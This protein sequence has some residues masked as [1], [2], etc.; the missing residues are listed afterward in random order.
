M[1]PPLASF[2]YKLSALRFG[3]M[4]TNLK[5]DMFTLV[6]LLGYCEYA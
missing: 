4:P 2:M 3:F 5:N 6:H 1:I